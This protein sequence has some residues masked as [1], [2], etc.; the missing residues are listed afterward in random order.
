MPKVTA[1]YREARRDEITAAAVRTFASKGFA[2][3][4][5]ADIIVESGL[6]AGA[7]YGHFASKHEIMMAVAREVIG[8]RVDN[9]REFAA[10]GPAPSP[11]DVLAHML[12]ALAN[13]LAQPPLL[14]QVWGQAMVEEGMRQLLWDVFADLRD[15]YSTYFEVWAREHE[16]LDEAAAQ[17]WAKRLLPIAVGLGQGFIVQSAMFEDF[18]KEAYLASLR[19]FLPH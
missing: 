10:S 7:I 17:D 12:P 16:G 18:D 6:S 8:S 3:A 9:L 14:L 15:T 4:S 2:H 13:D 1:Q 19:E 5:M 11:S